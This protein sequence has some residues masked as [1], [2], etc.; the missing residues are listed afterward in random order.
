MDVDDTGEFESVLVPIRDSSQRNSQVKSY[1]H[2]IAK[3]A[4][5]SFKVSV[6]LLRV[7]SKLGISTRSTRCPSRVNAL[8]GCGSGA[9]DFESIPTRGLESLHILMNCRAGVSSR[10]RLEPS[11]SQR[12]SRFLSRP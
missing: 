9:Q 12:F 11:N 6:S 4:A 7:S 1:T 2:V 10:I 8:A 3:D 5:T